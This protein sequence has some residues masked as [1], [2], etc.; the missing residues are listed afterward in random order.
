[1][2]GDPR[3]VLWLTFSMMFL[4]LSSPASS[5]R[6]PGKGRPGNPPPSAPSFNDNLTIYDTSL[7]SK[8]DG[9]AN[10]SPFDNG[11]SASAVQFGAEG[12]TIELSDTPSNGEPYTSGELRTTE[13]YGYGCY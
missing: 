8:A 13:F 7:W 5:E 9:W 6:P 1:M 10:G 11:W 3:H 4:F 12:M 2:I